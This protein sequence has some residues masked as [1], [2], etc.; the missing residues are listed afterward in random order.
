VCC[1]SAPSSLW[2]AS[3]ESTPQATGMRRQKQGVEESLPKVA[4]A[5]AARSEGFITRSGRQFSRQP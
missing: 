2:S 3:A 4:A 5:A 1:R